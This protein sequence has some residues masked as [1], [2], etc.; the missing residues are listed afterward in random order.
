[1][2]IKSLCV[3]A[4]DVKPRSYDFGTQP[5]EEG[6]APTGWSLVYP[7]FD[8]WER[9][10]LR[11]FLKGEGEEVPRSA[12]L[13]RLRE[14]ARE[15]ADNQEMFSPMMDYAYPLPGLQM[16]PDE[17]QAKLIGEGP[18]CVVM[19][20]DE[21]H[22]ALT[23]GGMDLSWDI[24]WAY[25]VLGYLPPVHF[26]G[27]LP[28]YGDGEICTDRFKLIVQAG[29]RSHEVMENWLTWG[30]DRLQRYKNRQVEHTKAQ[31]KAEGG[32]REKQ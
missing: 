6:E 8:S 24:C 27:T 17:A 3:K 16:E 1:M 26:C 7:D 5:L 2:N 20:D 10:A 19:V 31:A 25:M 28:D 32:A 9:K 15:T 14:M 22:L 30:I 12:T 4:I 13:W 21:P 23:G 29:L 18:V 11:D